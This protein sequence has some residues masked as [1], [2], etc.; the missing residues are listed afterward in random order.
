MADDYIKR[1]DYIKR[2]DA[3]EQLESIDWY[4]VNRDGKLVS[5]ATSDDDPFVRY[6]AVEEM[7]K[8]LPTAID[9]DMYRKVIDAARRMSTWI[10]LNTIDEEEVYRECGITPEVSAYLGY[11]GKAT[12]E[13]VEKVE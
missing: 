13:K 8:A 12:I 11:F 2:S 9:G 5:G 7:L 10:Y 3:L 1:K 4:H 6:D